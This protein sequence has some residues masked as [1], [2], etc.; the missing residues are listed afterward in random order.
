MSSKNVTRRLVLAATGLSA[1]LGMAGCSAPVKPG[2]SASE[3]GDSK[4]KGDSGDTLTLVTAYMTES[5][6]PTSG[7]G[8][9][10]SGRVNEGLYHIEPGGPGLPPMVPCLAAAEPEVSADATTW[11]VKLRQGVTFSD[12]TPLTAKDVAATY[13]YV[14]DPASASQSAE[15]MEVIGSVTATD[16]HTVV[17]KLKE[18]W[19]GL[20]AVLMMGINPAAKVVKGQKEAESSLNKAPIGT[21]PY[22]VEKFQPDRLVVKA[23]PR[24]RGG[25]PDLKGV[26]YVLAKDDNTRV[27][28]IVAGEFDGTVL[29]PKLAATFVNKPE[30]KVTT[31]TSADW[32]GVTLPKGNPV[33][34][35]PAVRM[36]LNIGIDR[37]VLVEKVLAGFGREAHTPAPPQLGAYFNPNAVFS[38][39]PERAKKLLEEAGWVLGPDKIRTKGNLRAAFTLMYMP[40]DMLRRDLAQV[41]ASEALALGFDI[42]LEGQPFTAVRPRI[43]QDSVVLGGGDLPYDPDTQMGREFNS[44]Y[45]DAAGSYY[46]NTGKFSSPEMDKQLQIGR[47]SLKQSEREAAYRKVQELFVANP[48]MLYLVFLDHTYVERRST[49]DKWTGAKTVLEPHEHGVQFGPWFNIEQ[50]KRK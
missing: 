18:P 15:I 8:L 29:P 10:G 20:K 19:A 35:D 22:L 5:L 34:A 9:A 14:L 1:A 26:T 46:S 49:S 33:T 13:N 41:V 36:A 28:R 38:Y 7:F 44:K 32:R 25:T 43:Q 47:T 42:K 45:P 48:S 4:P 30:F 2:S 39:D 31:A 21:G 11:T 27:Q 6:N 12:G 40:T 24:W 3:G 23:N 17:F 16:D 50:W 37:K